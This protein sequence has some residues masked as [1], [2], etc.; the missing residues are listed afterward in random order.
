MPF[1]IRNFS[2][3]LNILKEE[4]TQLVC[5]CPICEGHRLTI[6]KKSGAYKCWSGG[7]AE[8]EIR[9]AIAPL[10]NRNET[11]CHPATRQ[12][13]QKPKLPVLPIAGVQLAK[14][15]AP[16]TDT[17][18]PQRGSDKEHGE[19]LKTTYI[20]SLTSDGDLRQWV[21]RTDWSDVS[22]PKGRSKTFRQWH[23]DAN[24]EAVCRKG[25]NDWEPYRIDEFIQTL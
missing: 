10:P 12:T 15:P 9:N 24:G 22:K 14:L 11:L 3:R 2:S 19:V 6:S 18:Q 23:R 1:D 5:E 25:G 21:V 17:P 8:K 4:S 20:Y 13:P 16:A 7:C